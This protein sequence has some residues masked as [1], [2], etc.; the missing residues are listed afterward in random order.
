MAGSCDRLAP[1]LNHTP[2]HNIGAHSLRAEKKADT[3]PTMQEMETARNLSRLMSNSLWA[4]TD[5]FG[6]GMLK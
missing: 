4:R 1:Y 5:L 6:E 3:L 2:E